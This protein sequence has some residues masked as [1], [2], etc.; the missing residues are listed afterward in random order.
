[1]GLFTEPYIVGKLILGGDRETGV[2]L[3]TVD[4][5]RIDPIAV[6]ADSQIKASVDE[7]TEVFIITDIKPA[8]AIPAIETRKAAANTIVTIPFFVFM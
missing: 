4:I 3:E 1:M 8:L 2:L 6:L 5:I 7:V